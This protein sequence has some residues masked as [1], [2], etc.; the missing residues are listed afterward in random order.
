[1]VHM[2][3][4]KSVEAESNL[5]RSEGSCNHYSLPPRMVSFDSQIKVGI[6]SL[7]LIY[8]EHSG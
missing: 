1:M 7:S 2:E 5:T 6:V 3:K 4:L 8:G